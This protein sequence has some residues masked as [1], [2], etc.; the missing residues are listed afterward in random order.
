MPLTNRVDPFGEIFADPARGLWMGNRGWLHDPS[1]TLLRTWQLRRW[2][3]CQ[4]EFRGRHREVMSP[5][6]TWTE[7]FFLDEATAF[8]AGHRPCGEC[9][10]SA[11]RQFRALWRLQDPE[12]PAGA[13]EIDHHLHAERLIGRDT[14]R[15][16]RGEL[17]TLPDGTFIAD[18]RRAWLVLDRYLWAWSPAG[19][20]ERCARPLHAEVDVLTPPSV[21]GIFR[22]GYR[23]HIHPSAAP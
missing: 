20:V 15:T 16:S 11:Y 21:V 23:P 8:A 18:G 4:L 9:R 22:A 19:Y 6:R 14:K 12:D 2:I 10:H 5:R 7:L 17:G 13:D 3:I 1:R